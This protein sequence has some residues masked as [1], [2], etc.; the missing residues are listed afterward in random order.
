M[1]GRARVGV[2]DDAFRLSD[3]RLDAGA[4]QVQM[5]LLRRQRMEGKLL[6]RY[7][8]LSVGMAMT[9]GASQLHLFSARKW[10]EAEPEPR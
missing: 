7:G 9:R 5:E 1:S 6:A 8:K 2:G 4:F 3:F 10:Y